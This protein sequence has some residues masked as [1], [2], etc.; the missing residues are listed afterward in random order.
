MAYSETEMREIERDPVRLKSYFW[1]VA[2]NCRQM[3]ARRRNLARRGFE[4]EVD[5]MR[6]EMLEAVADG[7]IENIDALVESSCSAVQENS[8][9]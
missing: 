4:P 1:R 7:I 5:A 8:D 6:I 2:T 3:A 9:E